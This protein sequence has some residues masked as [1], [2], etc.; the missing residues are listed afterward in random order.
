MLTQLFI[1][2]YLLCLANGLDKYDVLKALVNA[3]TS[4]DELER[5]KD[6]IA[7]SLGG[8]PRF[9]DM[10]IPSKDGFSSCRVSARQIYSSEGAERIFWRV[11]YL[12]DFKG[13]EIN[14]CFMGNASSI[15]WIIFPLAS[16]SADAD[17][18]ILYANQTLARW[19]GLPPDRMLG[20]PFADYV[21]DVGA[22][23][24]LTLK[25]IDGRVFDAVLEQSQKDGLNGD[26]AYTRSIVFRDLVW[27]NPSIE[28]GPVD[29]ETKTHAAMLSE[30]ITG[31][32]N[33]RLRWLFDEAPV[34]MVFLDL[35]GAITD[36]NKSFLK[37][38][39]NHREAVLGDA[40]AERISKEDRGDV[41]AALSKI[42][43]GTARA[44]HMEARMPGNG[45]NEYTFSLYASPLGD[46]N[47]GS[48]WYS[49]L[50][51]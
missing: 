42:V 30:N 51:S 28:G 8:E 40:F 11:E 37:L 7:K 14:F 16:F 27:P 46:A 15:I 41:I 33:D 47:R 10:I 43:M 38:V 1:T 13:V 17:G 12:T 19:I 39:A 31:L 3:A 32:V 22:D 48:Q 6:F 36:C 25:D 49:A 34:G 5:L 23:G 18:V 24:R 35:A 26:I 50:L 4:L 20:T 2:F 45:A 9:S 21:N 29:N 44:T